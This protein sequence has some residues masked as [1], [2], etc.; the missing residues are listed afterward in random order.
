[1]NFYHSLSVIFYYQ[2][3]SGVTFFKLNSNNQLKTTITSRILPCFLFCLCWIATVVFTK[4]DDP[5]EENGD[6]DYY[7]TKVEFVAEYFQYILQTVIYSLV[8]VMCWIKNSQD[9]SIFK[10]YLDLDEILIKSFDF[11]THRKQL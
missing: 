3:V 6:T 11:K 2:R 7:H 8:F 9:A 1:M 4:L 5:S 10:S